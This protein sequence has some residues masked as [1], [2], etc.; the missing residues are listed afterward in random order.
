MAA[1]ELLRSRKLPQ[2]VSSALRAPAPVI[3]ISPLEQSSFSLYIHFV[4][5]HLRIVIVRSS[6]LFWPDLCPYLSICKKNKN[7]QKNCLTF[8]GRNSILLKY[9]KKT[10]QSFTLTS[11]QRDCVS[12]LYTEID[13][14]IF[15]DSGYRM[16]FC[17]CITG[18][19]RVWILSMLFI[20]WRVTESQAYHLFT[21][22]EVYYN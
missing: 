11:A 12:G 16:A 13:S 4:A 2:F 5:E 19:N 10:K 21:G 7:I 14:R 8:H 1:P 18:Y 20:F 15:W 17:S 6:L 3:S 9:V 22:M